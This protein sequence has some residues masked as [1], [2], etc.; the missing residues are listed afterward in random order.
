M[1]TIEETLLSLNLNDYIHISVRQRLEDGLHFLGGGYPASVI[2]RF[3]DKEISKS[4]IID[5]ILII[6]VR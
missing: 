2:R 6:Y 1:A 4:C 3:G 5:N